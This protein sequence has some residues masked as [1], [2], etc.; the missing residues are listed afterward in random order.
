MNKKAK[1]SFWTRVAIILSCCVMS[2]QLPTI[3]H[4]QEG[5]IRVGAA[6]SLTGRLAREGGYIKKGYE[7]WAEWINGRGGI[8]VAGKPYKVE[9]IVLRRQGRC[10]DERQTDRET[11]H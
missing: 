8:K 10:D 9:M 7:T 6:V 11:D 2:I 5:K 1:G 4:T 3:A